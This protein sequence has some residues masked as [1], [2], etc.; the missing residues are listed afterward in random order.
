[1]ATTNFKQLYVFDTKSEATV[2]WFHLQRRD[3]KAV[4]TGYG[5]ILSSTNLCDDEKRVVLNAAKCFHA[6]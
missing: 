3:I 2:F 6:R 4:N 5:V 1:M